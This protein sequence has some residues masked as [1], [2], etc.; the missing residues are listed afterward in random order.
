MSNC[1]VRA[2]SIAVIAMAALCTLSFRTQ[3]QSLSNQLTNQ[4][5]NR[6]IEQLTEQPTAQLTAQLTEQPPV[7][8]LSVAEQ[9]TNLQQY[10]LFLPPDRGQLITTEQRLSPVSPSDPS[11]FR[12]QDILTRRY[13][14]DGLIERWQVY[15]LQ[16]N[17]SY[18][19]I[20]VDEFLWRQLNYVRRYAFVSQLGRDAQR[21]GYH[22]RVFHT[23]D[24]TNR[25]ELL[26]PGGTMRARRTGRS[27]RSVFLRGT[28]FCDAVAEPDDTFQRCRIF[29]RP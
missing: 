28:H 10:P 14:A 18:V 17:L 20:I 2:G 27:S 11:L 7:P 22:L 4:L 25:R 3:A 15:Q 13:D 19:D 6:P 29:V 26:A 9:L 5:A 8:E 23:G 16:N 21:D 1:F 12:I 24:A